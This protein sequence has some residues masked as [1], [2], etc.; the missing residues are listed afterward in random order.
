LHQLDIAGAEFIFE[1]LTEIEREKYSQL[2]TTFEAIGG[3]E[4]NVKAKVVRFSPETLPAVTTLA[5]EAKLLMELRQ[6]R[7]NWRVPENVRDVVD[8]VIGEKPL[9]LILYLNAN[10]KIIQQIVKTNQFSPDTAMTLLTVYNNALLL[11][12]QRLHPRDAEIMVRQSTELIEMFIS[13]VTEL[14]QTRSQLSAIQIALQEQREQKH[15]TELTSHVRCFIA[16]PFSKDYD[17]LFDALQELFESKPYYWEVARAD[18]KYLKDEIRGNIQQLMSQSHCYLAEI[19]ELNPNVMMELG[20]MRMHMDRPTF[21]L[22]KK[23]MTT[24]VPANL[25]GVIYL[26][27]PTGVTSSELLNS[28]KNEFTKADVIKHIKGSA[29]YLSPTI[30]KVPGIDRSAIDVITRSYTTVEEFM[31]LPVDD[32]AKKTGVLTYLIQA[33]RDHLNDYCKIT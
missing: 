14:E 20:M 9:P 13:K 21:L 30:L 24:D 32:V 31:S 8:K 5:P 27:Y 10:N 28:L 6:T 12:Q 26:A 18:E 17:V 29:K 7:E 3:R 22:R 11:S 1:P 25:K 4:L 23:E 19:S 33:L 2:E 16:M 15:S